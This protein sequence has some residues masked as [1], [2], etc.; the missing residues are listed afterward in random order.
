MQILFLILF[1]LAGIC[2]GVAAA[3]L[4]NNQVGTY[5]PYDLVALGLLFWVLVPLIQTI[6]KLV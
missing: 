4:R 2:F 1:L 3:R 5:D 6:D